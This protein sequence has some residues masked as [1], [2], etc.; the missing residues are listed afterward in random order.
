MSAMLSLKNPTLKAILIGVV[1]S[2]ILTAILMCV[3]SLFFLLS[4][5]LPASYLDYILLAVEAVG[6]T[7]GAYIAARISKRQGLLT[8]LIVAGIYLSAILIAGFSSK[9]ETLSALT[10]IR[11]GVILLCGALSGIK[12]VN[13]KEKLHIK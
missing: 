12:G 4:A 8:G 2:V 10:L 13:K 3:L 6:V 9:T 5:S 7:V 1:S 11:A